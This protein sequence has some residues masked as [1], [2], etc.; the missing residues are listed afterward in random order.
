MRRDLFLQAGIQATAKAISESSE[1]VVI[2]AE[3]LQGPV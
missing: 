2:Y 3:V 1:M